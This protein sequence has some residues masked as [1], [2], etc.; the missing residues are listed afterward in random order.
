V[1]AGS[2]DP[3]ISILMRELNVTMALTG[4]RTI[5]EIDRTVLMT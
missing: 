1:A 5:A 3:S 4:R 2:S